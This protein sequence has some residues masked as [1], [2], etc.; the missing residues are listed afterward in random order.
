MR[1]HAELKSRY[2]DWLRAQGYHGPDPWTDY[3]IAVQAPDGRSASGWNMRNVHLPARVREEHSE[4][5]YTVS[6]AIDFVRGEADA[7][8]EGLPPQLFDLRDDPHEF[9][10]RGRDPA[11]AAVRDEMLAR[12]REG[13]LRLKRRTTITLASVEASTDAYKRAGVFYGQ[14]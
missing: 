14:W 12:L 5:A 13:S 2:A 4:T 9:A 6:E 8:W 10:D 11:L 7:P 3:V 1:H